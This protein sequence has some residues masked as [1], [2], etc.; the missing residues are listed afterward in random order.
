[1]RLACAVAAAV[2]AATAPGAA[3]APPLDTFY[4]AQVD[5]DGPLTRLR[6]DWD[7]VEAARYA[8]VAFPT[9]AVV[10][11][12]ITAT[13]PDFADEGTLDPGSVDCSKGRAIA[14]NAAF[15]NV[16]DNDSNSHGTIVAG[17]AAAPANGFGIVG[18]SPFSTLTVVRLGPNLAGLACGLTHLARQ[19]ET[20]QL[21]VLVVN[22]SLMNP[23]ASPPAVRRALKRLVRQGALVVAATGNRRQGTRL[24][25]PA[26]LPH[27][28]AVGDQEGK[29]LL[30]GPELDLLAPGGDLFAPLRGGDWGALAE[31]TTSW[32]T[33]LASGAAAAVWGAHPSGSEW[34]AQQLGYVLRTTAR[35]R[36]VW[37]ARQG[38]GLIDVT[39]ALALDANAVPRD[40][41][42]EPNDDAADATDAARTGFQPT[43]ACAAA[44]TRSGIIGTTDDPEDWWQVAVP[45]GRRACASI[46]KGAGVRARIVSGGRA[47]RAY[48]RVTTTKRL[49]A[50]TLR[51]RLA[52]GC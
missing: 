50:Y 52:A 28:L 41:E 34:T 31:P 45:A 51:V 9:V 27:V 20:G 40:D 25:Y 42:S 4:P 26:R 46:T 17:L 2:V 30:P 35:N 38:F 5:A 7:L 33:A 22:L 32:A 12:G 1:V 29:A 14:A 48:V 11:S 47:G 21:G 44:C 39:R 6:W 13:N 3:A 8:D 49:A 18:A 43:L 24:G 16:A 37:R 10:D 23:N 36:G 19:L 15:S